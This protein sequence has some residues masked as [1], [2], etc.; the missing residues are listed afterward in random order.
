MTMRECARLQSM[1]GL[2]HLP[3]V[4]T[5]AYKALGNAVNVEVVTAVAKALIGSGSKP[6]RKMAKRKKKKKTGASQY[7]KPTRTDIREDRISV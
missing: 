6:K 4:Q 1:G 7:R 2:K 5:S 3:K